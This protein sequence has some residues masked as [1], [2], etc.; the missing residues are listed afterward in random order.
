[1]VDA[2]PGGALESWLHREGATA[3]LVRPDGTV[4]RAGRDV[5]AL[6]A[7][8]VAQLNRPCPT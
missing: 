3:A 4:M 1:V 2:Q 8:M 6:C 5:G 7:W